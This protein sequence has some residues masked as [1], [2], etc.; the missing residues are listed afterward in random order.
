M[1]IND[2]DRVFIFRRI[3]SE[4]YSPKHLKN[5]DLL[6]DEEL[7]DILNA[8]SL[9]NCLSKNSFKFSLFFQF[10]L[11]DR[12]NT[13]DKVV[14]E[15]E[16][17]HQVCS[18][19]SKSE[20][21]V[22]KFGLFRGYSGYNWRYHMSRFLKVPLKPRDVI[23]GNRRISSYTFQRVFA[24]AYKLIFKGEKNEQFPRL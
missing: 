10:L 4:D 20:K 1:T 24:F 21:D 9:P 14:K 3:I 12:H 6:S 22:V 13:K 23:V 15:I 19:M 5:L 7:L 17:I 2:Q 8:S 18:T 11:Y 16:N